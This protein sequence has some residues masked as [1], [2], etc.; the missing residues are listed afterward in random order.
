MQDP[1]FSRNQTHK[2]MIDPPAPR[3]PEPHR[4]RSQWRERRPR[5]L[6]AD[7]CDPLAVRIG[8]WLGAHP[9]I[10]IILALLVAGFFFAR[11]AYAAIAWHWD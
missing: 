11:V 4:M 8:R 2:R 7:D 1:F 3:T 10:F 9:G 5:H 6:F